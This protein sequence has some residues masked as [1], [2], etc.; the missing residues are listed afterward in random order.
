MAQTPEAQ[1]RE[2]IDRLLTAAGWHVCGV[3]DA[4][5]HAATGVANAALDSIPMVV[6]SG[7]VPTHYYGKHPHQEVNLHADAPGA[8]Y[9]HL[10]RLLGRRDEGTR[11]DGLWVF[12]QSWMA[13][14]FQEALEFPELGMPVGA[15]PARCPSPDRTWDRRSIRPLQVLMGFPVPVALRG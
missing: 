3:K 2:E 8:T 14:W 12:P 1:A 15:L 4:N 9:G 10:R 11:S 5:I 6:I 13:P 7:D